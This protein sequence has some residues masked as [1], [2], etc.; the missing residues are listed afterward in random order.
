MFFNRTYKTGFS[1]I[2]MMVSFIV[3]CIIATAITPIITKKIQNTTVTVGGGNEFSTNCTEKFSDSCSLCQT[4]K[5]VLCNKK[6]PD[7]QKLDYNSCTCS[8]CITTYGENCLEC[9]NTNC[10]KC[11]GQFFLNNNVCEVCPIGSYCDGKTKTICPD[12]KYTDQVGQTSCQECPIG[13]FCKD[14]IKN[15][16]PAGQYSQPN[17]SECIPCPV[18]YKCE[19]GSDKIS[20]SSGAEYSPVSGQ[21]ECRT[22]AV[23]SYV[24]DN[25]IICTSCPKGYKCTGD[26]KMTKCETA[27]DYQSSTGQSTC[28]TCGAGY[29]ISSDRTSCDPCPMGYKCTGNGSKTACNNATGTAGN[30]Y[31]DQEGQSVCKTCAGKVGGNGA[32]CGS[33]SDGTYL[34]NDVCQ[35]CPIN[36]YCSGGSKKQCWSNSQ[37]N[38]TTGAS[39][40]DCKTGYYLSA[41]ETCSTCSSKTQHCKYCNQT[42]G[43]CTTCEDGYIL[44]NDNKCTLPCKDN[45]MEI[46]INGKKLCITKYNIGDAAGLSIPVS[47]TVASADNQEYCDIENNSCCW[48]G[49]TSDECDD[50]SGNY[51]GC[52]RTVCNYN[53]AEHI[54]SNLKYLNRTW[55]LPKQDELSSNYQC[56]LGNLELCDKYAGLCNKAQCG[57]SDNCISDKETLC[58]PN[59]VWT[60][61]YY[62]A[63][64]LYA[65]LLEYSSGQ[66]TT[67]TLTDGSTLNASVRCVSED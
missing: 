56:P 30:Q 26:G 59:Y 25:R 67:K 37:P 2:E 53:A 52:T 44:N 12:G 35:T 6:C 43:I 27:T 29:Y 14:G 62:S 9:N 16:C 17:A 50:A 47:V 15:P 23:G 10:T 66:L 60:N 3:I 24:L 21:S 49:T 39:T 4:N 31:Q 34:L 22:C 48:S 32:T 41:K 40:C 38:T 65:N 55:R 13:Y 64:I 18:G 63:G 19:G 36:Y 7:D 28:A 33:C 54:C 1:L 20:C 5:C 51:D 42:D 57:E 61:S 11:S 58:T 8:S 45:A 46:T